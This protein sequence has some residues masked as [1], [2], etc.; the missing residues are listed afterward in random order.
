MYESIYSFGW[1]SSILLLISGAC[2]GGWISQAKDVGGT[3]ADFL[4]IVVMLMMGMV[5]FLALVSLWFLVDTLTSRQEVFNS[6][7][8]IEI[9]AA[10][11]MIYI[12]GLGL[13]LPLAGW[14]KLPEGFV[15]ALSAGA[16][17]GLIIGSAA[18][19]GNAIRALGLI[20]LNA[21]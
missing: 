9:G 19:T 2:L 21:L 3:V 7:Y 8:V 6:D 10:Y 15:S 14:T 4:G 16:V 17:L 5:H 12:A 20:W 11:V 13:R 18:I 1:L